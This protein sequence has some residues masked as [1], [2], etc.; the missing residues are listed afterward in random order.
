MHYGLGRHADY[1]SHAQI[2][3]FR[4]YMTL[5][6]LLSY[7]DQF[8]S[9]ASILVFIMR[10]TPTSLHWPRRVA[11]VAIALNLIAALTAE[12]GF[13]IQCLPLSGAWNS[14]AGAKCFS[15]HYDV[16]IVYATSC[17]DPHWPNAGDADARTALNIFTDLIAAL[18]PM[19]VLR[20]LRVT[21]GLKISIY[22]CMG[23][24]L[25]CAMCSAGKMAQVD[26]GDDFTCKNS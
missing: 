25:L 18:V 13:G 23:L 1:L 10:H 14:D 2:A 15:P 16:K 11:W 19:I 21:Q 7:I 22:V 12:I 20:D 24:G 4:K 3:E 8:F 26:F 17:M 9:R 5:G 6:L